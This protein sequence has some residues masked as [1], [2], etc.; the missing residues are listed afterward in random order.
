MRAFHRH[1]P[2]LYLRQLPEPVFRWPLAERLSFTQDRE[3]HIANDFVYLKQ[4]FKRLPAIHVATLRAVVHHLRRV[5]MAD[6]KMDVSNLSIIF[7]SILFGEEEVKD[8]RLLSTGKDS[9]L[10]DLLFYAGQI[11]TWTSPTEERPPVRSQLLLSRSNTVASTR[12][13]PAQRAPGALAPGS[14]IG[15]AGNGGGG[16]SRAA[17]AS[18]NATNF[19]PQAMPPPPPVAP[20][21]PGGGPNHLG[22]QSPTPGSRSVHGLG[23]RRQLSWKSQQQEIS[24]EAAAGQRSH[25]QEQQAMAPPPLPRRSGQ[26]SATGL[27]PAPTPSPES[28]HRS[29]G[30]PRSVSGPPLPPPPPPP[31][32]PLP[33]RASSGLEAL[34]KDADAV[35]NKLMSGVPPRSSSLPSS[36]ASTH[37]A[38]LQDQQQQPPSQPSPSHL[39]EATFPSPDP[40]ETHAL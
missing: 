31:P 9:A 21:P 18:S 26:V 36:P 12:S 23:H 22:T 14:G 16:R 27:S 1:R 29:G 28:S 34:T 6:N 3:T 20:A 30:S 17:S 13:P 10:E 19:S 39:H 15:S 40:D 37:Q 24:A 11:F 8:I 7:S 38:Q 5:S 33:A 4:K 2:Q 25:A 35:L 32:P